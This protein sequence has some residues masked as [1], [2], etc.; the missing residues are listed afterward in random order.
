MYVVMDYILFTKLRFL[1][2]VEFKN[3]KITQIVSCSYF[4]WDFGICLF[5]R[6]GRFLKCNFT[7]FKF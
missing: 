3:N 7:L 4:F 6:K 5:E 1:T 2:V